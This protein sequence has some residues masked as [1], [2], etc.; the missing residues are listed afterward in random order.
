MGERFLIY[1]AKKKGIQQALDHASKGNFRY[2]FSKDISRFVHPWF[3]PEEGSNSSIKATQQTV[4]EKQKY[5][6][7]MIEELLTC[8]Y[9]L[10]HKETRNS[11][12]SEIFDQTVFARAKTFSFF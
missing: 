6:E 4:R 9:S 3:S 2:N 8:V 10:K 5:I 1:Y 7:A 12:L 11:T